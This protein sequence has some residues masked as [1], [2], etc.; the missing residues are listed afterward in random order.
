MH[1]VISTFAEPEHAATAVAA[2][3]DAGFT[4]DEIG[5][6]MRGELK[7][8]SEADEALTGAGYGALAGTAVGGL[9]GLLLG[10]A[11]I[12][13]PVLGP[14][15]AGGII[16]TTLGGAAT[17]AVYGT[18]LGLVIKL[19]LLG[20]DAQ[21]YTETLAQNGVILVVEARGERAARAWRL[22]HE[23][24]ATRTKSTIL[25]QSQNTA[26]AMP[27]IGLFAT[28]KEAHQAGQ[29]LLDEGIEQEA[30]YL[31]DGMNTKNMGGGSGRF[32]LTMPSAPLNVSPVPPLAEPPT[33]ESHLTRLGIDA[34]DAPFYLDAVRQGG[35][36]LIVTTDDKAEA[37][38][39]RRV[40]K[41]MEATQMTAST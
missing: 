10:A 39:S 37:A 20:E 38:T 11:S 35:A 12:S 22:M 2:L 33:A 18:L 40:M 32:P 29:Q 1:V 9:F 19:G 4:K 26:I 14:I 5:V 15:L 17:G 27:V 34:A 6:L 23:A 25:G 30:I 31:V 8:A 16:A 36:L 3:H 13:V 41:A 28:A 7:R 21:F 24:Q